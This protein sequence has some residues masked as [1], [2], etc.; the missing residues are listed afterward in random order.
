MSTYPFFDVAGNGGVGG[1]IRAAQASNSLIMVSVFGDDETSQAQQQQWT[2]S[3]FLKLVSEK[4]VVA[5]N[6]S[7]GTRDGLDFAEIFPVLMLP[8]TYVLSPAGQQ[9]RVFPGLVTAEKLVTSLN[10][11]ASTEQKAPQTAA[12]EAAGSAS[13]AS[14]SAESPSAAAVPAESS[15]S[16]AHP[17]ESQAPAK[18]PSK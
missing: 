4:R 3:A 10:E 5:L 17:A 14:A 8:T 7:A 2:D 1:A 18:K 16:A 15:A 6:L 12:G 9:L 11:L 13:S